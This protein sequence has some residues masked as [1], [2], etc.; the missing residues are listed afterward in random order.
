MD[1]LELVRSLDLE[2]KT[3]PSPHS[4]RLRLSRAAIG[5]RERI[6]WHD[7]VAPSSFTLAFCFFSALCFHVS[8]RHLLGCCPSISLHA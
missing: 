8:H 4:R 7:W 2:L 1:Q 6:A 5:W 3:G